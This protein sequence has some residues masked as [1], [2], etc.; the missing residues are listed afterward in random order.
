MLISVYTHEVQNGN[1]EVIAVHPVASV[2][3]S[4]REGFD[5]EIM[6]TL[7]NELQELVTRRLN[8][9]MERGKGKHGASS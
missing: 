7:E 2:E 4:P 6:R 5:H 8:E 9:A 1:G 3:H